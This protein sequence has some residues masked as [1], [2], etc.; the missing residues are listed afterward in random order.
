[1][2]RP[3]EHISYGPGKFEGES[4]I[5]RFAYENFSNP[6]DCNCESVLREANNGEY[7][8]DWECADTCDSRVQQVYGPFTQ[9]DV[10]SFERDNEDVMCQECLTY[11]LTLES[12][13]Y[14]ESDQGFVYASA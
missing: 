11:L 7:S 2:I 10:D 8:E 5:A 6:M 14:T 9:A 13:S 4:C 1:M 3:T 12:V